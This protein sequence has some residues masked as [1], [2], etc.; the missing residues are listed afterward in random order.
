MIQQLKEL[1]RTL[2]LRDPAVVVTDCDEALINALEAEYPGVTTLLCLFHVNRDVRAHCRPEFD[3]NEENFNT[4]Y[5]TYERVMYAHTMS[6][7]KEAWSNLETEYYCDPPSPYEEC[8]H[9]VRNTWFM[10][11]RKK[12]CRTWTNKVLHFDT[13]TTS[14]LEAMHRV[15][16]SVLRF[17]TGDLMTVVD[18]IEIMIMNQLKAYRTA[19]DEKKMKRSSAFK[20]TVFRDLIGRVTS[21][22][23][24]KIHKQ[25]K[26]YK[27]ETPHES[28]GPCTNVYRTT[29]SLPCAH[30][31]KEAAEY[32]GDLGQLSID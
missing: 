31:I 11:F 6:E 16:K 4:F 24:W 7:L 22:A 30:I 1:Y 19:I 27:A 12:I 26:L 13:T 28:L 14:R 29:M 15:L 8:Y 23:L 5:A 18:D 3:E 32:N 20:A 17:S 10:P 25:W 21:H 2:G 9:Y